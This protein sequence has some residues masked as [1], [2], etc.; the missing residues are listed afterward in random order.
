MSLFS[1]SV[2]FL[3]NSSLEV[4]GEVRGS[5]EP[6]S[7]RPTQSFTGRLSENGFP[8]VRNNPGHQEANSDQ[9][10]PPWRQDA[11]SGREARSTARCKVFFGVLTTRSTTRSSQSAFKVAEG[12]EHEG[13]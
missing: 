9:A 8:E 11:E 2:S 5:A 6:S 13:A 4:I 12:I 3:F 1:Y 7:M 10:E